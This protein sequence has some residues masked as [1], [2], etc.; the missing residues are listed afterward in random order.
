MAKLHEVFECQARSPCLSLVK[1]ILMDVV[2]MRSN[3][4]HAWGQ[5]DLYLVMEL[6]Q[7]LNDAIVVSSLLSNSQKLTE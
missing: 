2:M 6:L 5:D 1:E 7:G 3:A 4:R